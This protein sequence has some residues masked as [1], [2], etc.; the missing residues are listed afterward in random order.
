MWSIGHP[1]RWRFR[2]RTINHNSNLLGTIRS[3]SFRRVQ[4]AL[5]FLSWN[6]PLPPDAFDVV[7]SIYAAEAGDGGDDAAALTGSDSRKQVVDDSS[8]VSWFVNRF[9]RFILAF[10]SNC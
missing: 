9:G 4:S 7:S 2:S 1:N 5:S 8:L 6:L 3:Q 10:G